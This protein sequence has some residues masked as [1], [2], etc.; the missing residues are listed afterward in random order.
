MTRTEWIAADVAARRLVTGPVFIAQ[1]PSEFPPVL[2]GDAAFEQNVVDL[3]GPPRRPSAEEQG[4]EK[5]KQDHGRGSSNQEDIADVLSGHTL[6]L[7]DVGDDRFP[8]VRPM[9]EVVS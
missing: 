2:A 6:P 8:I 7:R 5:R 9:L 3:G 1:P 4:E